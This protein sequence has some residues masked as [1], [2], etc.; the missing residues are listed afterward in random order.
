MTTAQTAPRRTAGALLRDPAIVGGAGL[1][2]AVLLHL[3]DPHASGSY[4]YCPF[5]TLTGLPCPGC[6]GLRAVNDLTRGEVM[7]AVSSNLA[8]VCLVAFLAVS[9]LVWTVRRARGRDVPMVVF[10]TRAALVVVPLIV[11]FGVLRN[12]PWGAWLA[13]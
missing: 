11:V 8:A 4:G 3:H 2:A 10:T 13:P 6:G 7:A 9:W 5:L 1:G 12:T